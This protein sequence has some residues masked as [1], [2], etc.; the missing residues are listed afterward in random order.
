MDDYLPKPVWSKTLEK[1]LIKWTLQKR[2][3]DISSFRCRCPSGADFAQSLDQLKQLDMSNLDLEYSE[4]DGTASSMSTSPSYS[5]TTGF[6][7]GS[8]EPWG[9]FTSPP[10]EDK[11][12]PWPHV[13]E[14]ATATA[15]KPIRRPRGQRNWT[16]A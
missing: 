5:Q 2:D 14:P 6:S 16:E 11:F 3:P 7:I 8:E 15:G 4:D 9:R 12:S 10:S 1:M 13:S